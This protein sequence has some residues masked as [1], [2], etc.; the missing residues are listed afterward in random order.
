MRI[1]SLLMLATMLA[2]APRVP[3]IQTGPDAEVTHDG[4]HRVTGAR[5]I[6]R[7]WVKPNLDLQP[8][9]KLLP[10]SAGIH[11]RRP[12][13]KASREFALSEAQQEFIRDGLRTALQEELER[14]GKWEFVTEPGPDVLVMRGA[15][16]D[17][18]VTASNDLSAR[19][20]S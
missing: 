18:V 8:Y 1:L 14:R 19:D 13:R 3:T 10:V 2:C 17:L 5:R 20:S 11:F 12:P 15:I 4:L 6:Q 7:A 9:S 16:I